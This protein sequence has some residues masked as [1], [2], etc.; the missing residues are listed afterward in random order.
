M[1]FEGQME[2]SVNTLMQIKDRLSSFV[3]TPWFMGSMAGFAA[4]ASL[5]SAPFVFLSGPPIAFLALSGSFG[6]LGLGFLLGLLLLVVGWAALGQ[7]S[8]SGF[9]SVLLVWVIFT[10]LARVFL[11]KQSLHL[12]L[13][14]VAALMSLKVLLGNIVTPELQA[15]LPLGL[16]EGHDYRAAIS[17]LNGMEGTAPRLLSGFTAVL[18]G[19]A[20]FGG[21]L[22]SIW[23]QDLVGASFRL[24]SRFAE[25][26]FSRW[27]IFFVVFLV[28][29]GGL[30][31]LGLLED[32]MMVWISV[33]AI[34]GL[35][36][37]DGVIQVRR[38]SRLWLLPAYV[39]LFLLP[40]EALVTLALV[41]S[42]DA[43]V[44]FRIQGEGR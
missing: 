17:S 40:P 14:I 28:W 38:L 2:R 35:S 13:L 41:G 16:G 11:S 4:V 31:S 12:P 34:V 15:L 8:V 30:I 3:D 36:V 24:Q 44:H 43:F 21:F 10:V 23:A 19:F 33:Y 42:V 6:R 37:L 25:I 22:F 18:M 29:L 5:K 39:L 9:S 1:W 27:T 32:L 20:L 26:S 7:G